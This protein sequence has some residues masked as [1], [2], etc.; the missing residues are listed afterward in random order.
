MIGFRLTANGSGGFR[1]T[2]EAWSEGS[3]MALHLI[4]TGASLAN[5]DGM[6]T[7]ERGVISQIEASF[8]KIAKIRFEKVCACGV[9]FTLFMKR[10][11]AFKYYFDA[12]KSSAQ[13]QSELYNKFAAAT[14]EVGDQV[15]IN[16]CTLI[17]DFL[18]LNF[19]SNAPLI[20]TIDVDL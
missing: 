13:I 5:K 3:M 11:I 20:L 1:Q 10:D 4:A 8:S 17:D 2:K 14:G 6:H 18:T 12:S 16:F 19:S 7:G 15:M 9:N